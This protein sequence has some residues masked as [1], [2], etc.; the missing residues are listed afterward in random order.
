VKEARGLPDFSVSRGHREHYKPRLW[1]CFVKGAAAV[2]VD[3]GSGDFELMI[4][5]FVGTRA[6]AGWRLR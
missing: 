2:A 5:D 3:R 4:A 6:E 1:G